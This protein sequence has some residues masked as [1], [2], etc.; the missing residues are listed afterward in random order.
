MLQRLILAYKRKITGTCQCFCDSTGRIPSD[1]IH[2]TKGRIANKIAIF[3]P[4][5]EYLSTFHFTTLYIS[6][7]LSPQ[8]S[9]FTNIAGRETVYIM[10]R[11]TCKNTIDS[12]VWVVI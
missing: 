10:R 11:T 2:S 1:S 12:M 9:G 8:M 5:G 4:A 7:P 3:F 6:V